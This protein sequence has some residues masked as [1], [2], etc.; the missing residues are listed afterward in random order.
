MP[1]RLTSVVIDTPDPRRL[2]GFWSEALGWPITHEGT[3]EVVV[4]RDEEVEWGDGVAPPLVFVPVGDAKR[5]K[6]RVHLDLIPTDAEDQRAR[7]ERLLALG[8]APVDIG[9]GEVPW[10]VL[11]DPDGNEL[12]VLE[13]REDYRGIADVAAVVL[14]CV[15][16]H[17]LAAFWSEAS[18]WPAELG[19][20]WASLRNPDAP[21]TRLELIAVPEPTRAKN[22]VHLDVAPHRNDDQAAEVARLEA[23]GACR[24]DIG[25]GDVPWVVLAD[26]E[27]NELCVL[28]PR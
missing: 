11:A 8:A 16:P 5:G 19:D 22:R 10:T 23:A 17:R 6:N 13:P 25:Q 14:D 21:A 26:P 20:G 4:E 24:I 18:G 27:G 28:T 12:C 7:V 2:A 1:T 3:T 9:Q 15:D